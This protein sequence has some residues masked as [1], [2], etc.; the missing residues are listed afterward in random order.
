MSHPA[1]KRAAETHADDQG[2][3]DENTGRFAIDENRRSSL[4]IPPPADQA[5]A[6]GLENLGA[7]LELEPDALEEVDDA[8]PESPRGVL[9][10]V[11]SNRP[12]PPPP[13]VR[14]RKVVQQERQSE[15][16]RL[17]FQDLSMLPGN[18]YAASSLVPP[19]RQPFPVA[20]VALG[21]VAAVVL[22]G[23]AWLIGRASVSSSAPVACGPL[24]LRYLGSRSLNIA[25]SGEATKIDE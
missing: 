13:S 19:P 15:R 21:V 20:K 16:A 14:P 3:T 5:D 12:P 9:S 8:A 7:V 24:R 11:F 1:Q 25:S 17:E 23:G 2:T 18:P 6:A 10:G 4:L 22:T